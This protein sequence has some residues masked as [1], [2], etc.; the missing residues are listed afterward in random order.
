M[1]FHLV[2][3]STRFAVRHRRPQ[4]PRKP[5][6]SLGDNLLDPFALGGLLVGTR[7]KRDTSSTSWFNKSQFC[8]VRTMLAESRKNSTFDSTGEWYPTVIVWLP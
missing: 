3:S 8:G 6:P 1:S 7:P 4:C 5:A 2:Y